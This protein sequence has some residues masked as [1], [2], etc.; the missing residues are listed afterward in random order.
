MNTENFINFMELSIRRAGYNVPAPNELLEKKVQ[1]LSPKAQDAW[2]DL[3]IAIRGLS[4]EECQSLAKIFLQ[5][6]FGVISLLNLTQQFK[7]ETTETMDFLH[8]HEEYLRPESL[9]ELFGG[10]L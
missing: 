4:D 5:K 9:E 10:L 6:F 8:E 1:R 3:M 2:D 7:E